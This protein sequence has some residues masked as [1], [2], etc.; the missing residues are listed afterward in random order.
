MQNPGYD[1]DSN[2]VLKFMSLSVLM[3]ITYS[4]WSIFQSIRTYNLYTIVIKPFKLE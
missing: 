3:D 2:Y 1:W 4:I